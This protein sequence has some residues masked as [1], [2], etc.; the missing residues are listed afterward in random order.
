MKFIVKGYDRCKYHRESEKIF[1]LIYEDVVGYEVKVIED[2]DP[3]VQGNELDDFKEYLILHFADGSQATFR[4][5]Y[6]DLIRW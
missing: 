4:N 5:S 3:Y 6:V 2:D 1:E